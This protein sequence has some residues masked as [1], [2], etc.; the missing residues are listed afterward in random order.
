MKILDTDFLIDFTAGTRKAVSKMRSI[1]NEPL[2]IS[3]VTAIELYAGAVNSKFLTEEMQT[4]DYT[5]DLL[6]IIAV[7]ESVRKNITL[8]YAFLQS[9]HQMI[10]HFDIVIAGTALTFDSPLIT[11]DKHFTTV[12]KHFGL[13]PE[14]WID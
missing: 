13:K 4:I 3:E 11:R 8:I 7:D 1:Q 6:N 12:S 5:L 14:S 10:P 9:N 2:I